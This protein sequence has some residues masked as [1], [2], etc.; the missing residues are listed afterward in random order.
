MAVDFGELETWFRDR[1]KWLQDA[2]R[3]LAERESLTDGDVQ[4]LL[5]ICSAEAA[6]PDATVTYRGMSPGGLAV[7]DIKPILRLSSISEVRGVN[8]L[9]PTKPLVF[10][11]SD[12]CVVYGGNGTGKSGYVRLLKHASGARNPG[13]LLGNVFLPS[14]EP[15]GATF[16]IVDGTTPRSLIWSGAP[17][18]D[19]RAV[20][21]FD[22][23]SG[24]FYVN[25]ESEIT[26]EP[27]LLRLFSRLTD[28]CGV[29]SGRIR[30]ESAA[31]ASRKPAWPT[32]LGMSASG[33][34]YAALSD[35]ASVEEVARWT[36]WSESDELA[37]AETERRL[38]ERDHAATAHSLRHR[39]DLVHG[40]VSE[41]TGWLDT[42]SDER[43]AVY[44]NAQHD[45]V[46]R[47][48]T[49]DGDARRVFESAPVEG[50]GSE[51]WR[52]LWEA[53]R[54]FSE[55]KAY[56][57]LSFPSAVEGVHCVLCQQELSPEGRDRMSSFEAFVRA[58]FNKGQ[59]RPRRSWRN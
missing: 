31:K 37:L 48:Q 5:Q 35:T 30:G 16:A 4:E 42:L 17:L 36:A 49:A 44:R 32:E 21:V 51:S 2:A 24:L 25:E 59:G 56:P 15:Q 9:S 14:P 23:S 12:L 7:V 19:L 3:R 18:A 28:A 13:V 38:G 50:V 57:E 8:A 53:A 52:A 46:V 11:D 47:R 33:T 39:R 34:W 40:V 43:C 20:D 29:L 10:S 41:F 1:A 45:A 54:K 26:F 55:A 58:S 27:W 22:T 6:A